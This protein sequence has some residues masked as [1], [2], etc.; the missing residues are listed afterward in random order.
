MFA[1]NLER[2]QQQKQK[3]TAAF[4]LGI[5]SSYCKMCVCL[6]MPPLQRLIEERDV[7]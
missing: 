7:I 3:P 5:S 4:V 2:Q 1:L 6:Q